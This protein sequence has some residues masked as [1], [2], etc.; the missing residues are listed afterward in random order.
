M[1]TTRKVYLCN[2]NSIGTRCGYG[3]G[4]TFE[5]AKQNAIAMAKLRDPNAFYDAQCG[6]VIFRAAV[7]L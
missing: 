2:S 4:S 7:N 6:Q 3:E 5:Q 1:E